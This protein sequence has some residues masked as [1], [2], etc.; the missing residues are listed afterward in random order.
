MCN[1]QT[2]LGVKRE[3]SAEFD[4]SG[5]AP[6]SSMEVQNNKKD[7]WKTNAEAAASSNKD[8]RLV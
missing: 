6:K 8:T 4:V 1:M 3:D 5:K 2:H 7:E